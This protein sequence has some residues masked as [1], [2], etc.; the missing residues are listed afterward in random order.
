VSRLLATIGLYRL[1]NG[2]QRAHYRPASGQLFFAAA[3]IVIF[4]HC[5]PAI[6]IL[7]LQHYV[8]AAGSGAVAEEEAANT[9]KPPSPAH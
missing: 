7:Q 6:V 5:A 3:K 4:M 1:I 9:P 2:L 8:V